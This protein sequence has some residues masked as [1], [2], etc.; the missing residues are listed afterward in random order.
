MTVD[1]NKKIHTEKTDPNVKSYRICFRTDMAVFTH[2]YYER[3]PEDVIKTIKDTYNLLEV[4]SIHMLQEIDLNTLVLNHD[5]G[6]MREGFII[7]TNKFNSWTIDYE[8]SDGSGA[9]RFTIDYCPFCGERLEV[10]K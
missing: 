5:C 9:Y 8:N 6:K 7:E 3:S 4:I 10:L 1:S 2:T